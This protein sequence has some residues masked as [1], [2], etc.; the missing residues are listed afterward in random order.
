[1]DRPAIPKK[2]RRLQESATSLSKPFRSPLRPSIQERLETP[3]TP[4]GV[5]QSDQGS[6]SLPTS[7]SPRPI[8]QIPVAPPEQR[9]RLTSWSARSPVRN[10][11]RVSAPQ[12][13]EEGSLA[14]QS[15][16]TSLLKQLTNLRHDL[17]TVLQA[18]KIESLGKDAELENLIQ[19]W[20]HAS[21]ELAEQVFCTAEERVSRT[22]GITAWRKNHQRLSSWDEAEDLALEDLTD[23]QREK[24]DIAK[25]EAERE[26]AYYRT[27]APLQEDD[28]EDDQVSESS[29][30]R[31]MSQYSY[32]SSFHQAFT[33]DMMLK[34]LNIDLHLI[35]YD[36][37]NQRW[38]D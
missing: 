1:M 21:R 18:E 35:G 8:R 4:E 22:G 19:K 34:S 2:R 37:E 13:G 30:G 11:K 31:D 24:I 32:I 15:E 29:S 16:H 36:K 28:E 14:L 3:P 33:M 17:D 20:K 26:K 9:T 12:V 10:L 38:I 27:K 23:E 7:S 5:R 25:A 6:E